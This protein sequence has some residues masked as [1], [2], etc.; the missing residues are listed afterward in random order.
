MYKTGDLAR[1]QPNG[2]IEYLGRSTITRDKIRGFRIE[3]SEIGSGTGT[4]PQCATMCGH[5]TRGS[6]RQPTPSRLYRI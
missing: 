3:L 2:D 6:T 1:Y 5:N 4:T